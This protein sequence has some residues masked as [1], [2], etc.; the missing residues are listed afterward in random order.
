MPLPLLGGLPGI[1]RFERLG[2]HLLW[3]EAALALG[4]DPRLDALYIFHTSYGGIVLRG[5][6]I[7]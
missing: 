5:R 7:N 1:A 6:G 3:E 2:A 4:V